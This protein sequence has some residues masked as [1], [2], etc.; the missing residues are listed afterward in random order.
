MMSRR[1]RITVQSVAR[2]LAPYLIVTGC[3]VGAG[4]LVTITNQI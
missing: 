1:R 3:L 2:F 4:L